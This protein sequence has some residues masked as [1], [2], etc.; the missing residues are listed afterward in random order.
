[1]PWP[2]S[3]GQGLL[4]FDDWM[5]AEIKLTAVIVF[6]FGYLASLSIDHMIGITDGSCRSLPIDLVR[7]MT[8]LFGTPS[9]SE[10]IPISPILLPPD[11][12]LPD[13]LDISSKKV[14]FA[15]FFGDMV[16]CSENIKFIIALQFLS[17]MEALMLSCMVESESLCH[18][19]WCWSH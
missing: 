12:L 4:T 18:F 7:R 14:T 2:S 3:I 11:N 10:D 9:A 16:G 17:V 5:E 13:Q 8:S 19:H 6:S 15:N 1:M